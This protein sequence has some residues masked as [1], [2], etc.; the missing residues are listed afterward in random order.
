MKQRVLCAFVLGLALP[1]IAAAQTKISGEI[2][3]A[4][5]DPT[6]SID[7]SDHA[8][9]ALQLNKFACTWTKGIEVDGVA[10]KDGT[11]VTTS[12][13]RGTRA[14]TTGYHVSNMANGDKTFV[15]FSGT[16]TV[17]KDGKPLTSVGTWSYIGGT[18]KFKGIKGKGTYNG[19]PDASGNMVSDI[20]GEYTLPK[21]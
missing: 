11:D 15:R 1:A 17:T 8:G 4:K 19:K 3:C 20:E 13:S 10:A 7:V 6:Y 14:H 9:H 16:D 5:P 21:M 2:S 18:G 12:D